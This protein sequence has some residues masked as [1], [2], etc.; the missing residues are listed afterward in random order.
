MVPWKR[1]SVIIRQGYLR[2]NHTSTNVHPSAH[3]FRPLWFALRFFFCWKELLSFLCCLCL[4]ASYNDAIIPL[5]LSSNSVCEGSQT[6]QSLNLAEVMDIREFFLGRSLWVTI[7]NSWYVT[8]IKHDQV[9]PW[10]QSVYTK[11]IQFS[12]HLPKPKVL[13]LKVIWNVL[14][15]ESLVKLIHL[16]WHGD[17]NNGL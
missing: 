2:A 14:F 6:E 5:T 7:K 12:L 1:V 13:T 10:Y 4:W 11:K 15:V 3:T 16:Y 8:F 17:W 9:P